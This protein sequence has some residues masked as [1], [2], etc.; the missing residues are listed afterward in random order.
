MPD[1]ASGFAEVAQ[2]DAR[3][4]MVAGR[5]QHLRQQRAS[6]RLTL[7]Q[8]LCRDL[9]LLQPRGKPVPDTLQLPEIEKPRAV[10]PAAGAR[11]PTLGRT[12]H[13]ERSHDRA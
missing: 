7:G 6:G 12:A 11:A 10:G 4:A 9:R 2:R 13:L 8:L 1:A 5:Q 3:E